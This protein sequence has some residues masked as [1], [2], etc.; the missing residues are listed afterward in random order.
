LAER[1]VNLTEVFSFEK[2]NIKI[3]KNSKEAVDFTSENQL[4]F[5][6]VA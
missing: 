6:I 2:A 4:L 5:A 1:L 3:V